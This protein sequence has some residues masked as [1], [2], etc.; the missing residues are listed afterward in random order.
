MPPDG[1]QF[2]LL[3]YLKVEESRGRD[4]GSCS[5]PVV[6][7]RGDDGEGGVSVTRETDG[8]VPTGGAHTRRDPAVE[9]GPAFA[10]DRVPGGWIVAAADRPYTRT[11]P[12]ETKEN[13]IE[14]RGAV[15]DDEPSYIARTPSGV[16]GAGLYTF[17]PVEG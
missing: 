5:L 17:G 3:L 13:Y 2:D 16:N 14:F 15:T 1:R 9:G 4:I 6:G 7:N 11:A 10:R 8:S 12:S